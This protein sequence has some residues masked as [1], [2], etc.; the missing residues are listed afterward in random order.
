MFNV[1][2]TFFYYLLSLRY[3]T[4]QVN[5]TL[6]LSAIILPAHISLIIKFHSS[7]SDFKLASNISFLRLVL[8]FRDGFLKSRTVEFFTSWVHKIHKVTS[9]TNQFE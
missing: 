8:I 1:N 2:F 5:F 3:F 4:A 7:L 9:N 6:W